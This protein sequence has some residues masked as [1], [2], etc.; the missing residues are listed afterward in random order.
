M[1]FVE[2]LEAIVRVADKCEIPHC[3][4]VSKISPFAT[5]SAQ[6]SFSYTKQSNKQ[7]LEAQMIKRATQEA[8]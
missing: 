6:E 1:I 5:L 7:Q 2:F 4:N 3:I 8:S